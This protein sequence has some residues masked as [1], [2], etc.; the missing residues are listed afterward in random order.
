MNLKI[1]LKIKP[2]TILKDRFTDETFCVTKIECTSMSKVGIC[3]VDTVYFYDENK[4]K[5]WHRRCLTTE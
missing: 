1:A 5:H 3:K 4:K 2:G